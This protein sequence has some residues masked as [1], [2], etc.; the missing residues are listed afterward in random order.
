MQTY[1]RIQFSKIATATLLASFLAVNNLYAQ[2]SN[3]VSDR[4]NIENNRLVNVFLQ[5]ENR[6]L[7]RAWYDL[8]Q[9]WS[10]ERKDY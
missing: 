4:I 2:D 3:L 8:K 6:L 1:N 10:T 7:N 5:E 9:D